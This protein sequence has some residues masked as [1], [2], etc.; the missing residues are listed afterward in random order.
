MS[1]KKSLNKVIS[2]F[3]KSQVEV[4]TTSY[5]YESS[6]AMALKFLE[7]NPEA[8]ARIATAAI[9]SAAEEDVDLVNDQIQKD[10][11]AELESFHNY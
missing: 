9:E 4:E 8:L 10:L 6:L 7:D 5:I 11:V 3:A 2:K 1:E